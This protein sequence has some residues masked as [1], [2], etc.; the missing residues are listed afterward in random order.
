M[1]K[2][3]QSL[4]PRRAFYPCCAS[5]IE[6][7]RQL[8]RGLVDEII[9]CDRRVPRDIKNV[10]QLSGLPAVRFVKGNVR[11]QIG[12]LPS[13][14]VLFYRRDS[15]GEGGSGVP[16]LGKEWLSKIISHFP[17][18][19]GLIITDGSK[20]WNHMFRRMTQINGYNW[21]SEACHL[22]PAA[23]QP[24]VQSHGLHRIEVT[25]VIPKDP[26]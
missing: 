19:G 15:D 11:E 25:R 17:P 6:E 8:L 22:R 10:E 13:I 21:K 7:P 24:W 26:S 23:E 20:S 2:R 4:S 18:E 14:N 9:F 16:I 12:Q 1:Q 3:S 5:D